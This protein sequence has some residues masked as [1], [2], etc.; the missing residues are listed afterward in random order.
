MGERKTI[1]M[2][3][4]YEYLKGVK[5]HPS[6]HDV[7]EHVKKEIPSITLATVYRNLEKLVKNGEAIKLEIDGEYRFDG[8]PAMHIHC[9]CKKCGKIID[10]HD[11]EMVEK[12]MNEISR[13]KFNAESVDIVYR[14]LCN[15]CKS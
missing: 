2:K 13:K 3:K 10:I 15:D 6:A 11:D 4:I 1:Q 12:A 8:Q 14:G 5:T 7:Y 9:V